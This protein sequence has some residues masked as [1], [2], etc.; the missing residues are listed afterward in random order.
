MLSD[1]EQRLIAL[2]SALMHLQHD[3]ELI[4]SIVLEQ[5]QQLTA[6]TQLLQRMNA[7]LED[8][9]FPREKFDP[10]AERPPH[11]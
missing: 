7:R 2:E 5:Q 4:N 8:L 11:Y 1:H 10:N 9:S 3:F 6:V